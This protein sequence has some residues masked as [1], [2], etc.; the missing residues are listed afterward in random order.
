MAGE[1]LFRSGINLGK[2]LT[3]QLDEVINDKGHFL[4]T[5]GL[6]DE[7][8]RKKAG[9]A[10]SNGL[11]KGGDYKIVFFVTEQR[12]R[13]VQQDATTIKLVHEA[14][15]EIKTSYGIIV[16]MVSKGVLKRLHKADVAY[17]DFLNTLFAGIPEASKCLY[18]NILFIGKIDDLEDEDDKLVSPE[19]FVD[20][21]G[22]TLIDFL[23][24]VVPTISIK[25]ENV[26]DINTDQFDDM[27]KELKRLAE[28]TRLKD[29]A[30]REER[31][32]LEFRRMEEAAENKK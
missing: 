1:C 25:G 22:L 15:P 16:N 5:P 27:T 14:A 26:A 31:R 24:T 2:G 30:W 28:E 19:T 3:Y 9:E 17:F 20:V 23:H 8:L 7:S 18:S 11:R 21:N 10:I 13:V 32:Q 6:A 4:D 12:G 29:E